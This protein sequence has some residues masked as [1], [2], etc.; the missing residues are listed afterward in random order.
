MRV[1]MIAPPGAGKGL[2]ARISAFRTSRLV[3]YR[4]ITSR[5]GPVSA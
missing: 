5:G 3:N 2:R 1:L 4:A